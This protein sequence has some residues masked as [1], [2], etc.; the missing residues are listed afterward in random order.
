MANANSLLE[1]AILESKE[2]DRAWRESGYYV[3]LDQTDAA[4]KIT[5]SSKTTTGVTNLIDTILV[6]DRIIQEICHHAFTSAIRSIVYFPRILAD[7]SISSKQ[8][9]SYKRKDASYFVGDTI[10][11]DLWQTSDRRA[12]IGLLKENLLLSTRNIPERALNAT[13]NQV[14]CRAIQQAAE[15]LE[16]QPLASFNFPPEVYN[17]RNMDQTTLRELRS[18]G[19]PPAPK[20]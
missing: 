2:R 18:Q 11:I 3:M 10:P 17:H 9:R 7:W 12:R 15:W 19:K 4:F 5:I 8:L 6:R 1:K 14:I 20:S 16:N 13:D